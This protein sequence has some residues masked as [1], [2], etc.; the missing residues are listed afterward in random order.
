MF[1]QNKKWRSSRSFSRSINVLY[2]P[3]TG[4]VNY[5][6]LIADAKRRKMDIAWR[7]K[8]MLQAKIRDM[9]LKGLDRKDDVQKQS[10]SACSTGIADVATAGVLIAGASTSLLMYL[11]RG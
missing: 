9:N 6:A 7:G 3:T 8:S 5:S 1:G 10:T 2:C 4:R 11:K